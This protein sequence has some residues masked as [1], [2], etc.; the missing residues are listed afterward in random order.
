MTHIIFDSDKINWGNYIKQQQVG[1]GKIMS[2]RDDVD[3]SEKDPNYFEGVRYMR[4]YGIKD[5]LTSVGRFLLPIASNLMESAKGEAQ[6][7]LGRIGSE[8]MQGA[9]IL[10][11]VKEQGKKGLRNISKKVQQCGKGNRKKNRR[12]IIKKSIKILGEQLADPVASGPSPIPKRQRRKDY[13]D[14]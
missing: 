10:E 7:T 12:Q 8:V 11:T 6:Q 9:P 5:A 13:L 1:E 3:S 4:G 14:I 2:N